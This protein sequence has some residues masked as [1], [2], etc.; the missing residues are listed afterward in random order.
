MDDIDKLL[1]NLFKEDDNPTLAELFNQRLE[2]LDITKTQAYD[3]LG[4]D[5]NS[6]EPILNNE[7]KQVDTIKLLKIGHFLNLGIEQTIQIYLDHNTVSKVQEFEK[8]KKAKFIFEN[9]NL[10]ILKKIGFIPDIRNFPAIEERILT[11]FGFTDIYEF[12]NRLIQKLAAKGRFTAAQKFRNFWLRT[13]TE[14]FESIAN[15]NPYNREE[16]MALINR[17]KPYSKN[18]VDGLYQVCR[19]LYQAGVTIL[20]QSKNPDTSITG[21]TLIINHKPCIVISDT[22]NFYGTVWLTLLNELYHIIHHFNDIKARTY[23]IIGES[24]LW[25]NNEEEAFDFARQYFL[26]DD[27][28]IYIADKIN[29]PKLVEKYA[30]EWQ[31]HPCLIYHIYCYG[32]ESEWVHYQHHDPGIRASIKKINTTLYNTETIAASVAKVKKNL[33]IDWRV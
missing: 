24:D 31:I 29:K 3:A 5:K 8:A 15:P 32:D 19:A 33:E 18:E 26:S 20:Y 2:E 13:T 30:H 16:L 11:Y 1:S 4:I 6:I 7:A 17:I 14:Q 28:L 21:A 25:L 22:H 10:P 27:Q 9:F 23:H 12:S